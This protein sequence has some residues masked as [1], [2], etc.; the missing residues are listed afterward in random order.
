MTGTRTPDLP[1]GTF[2]DSVVG[3]YNDGTGDKTVKASIAILSSALSQISN[4]SFLTWA[5]L[6]AAPGTT[7]GQ[8]AEVIGD[9]NSHIDPATGASVVNHGV[10][11]WTGTVWTH[12]SDY[13][14]SALQSEITAE[15]TARTTADTTEATARANGDAGLQAQINGIVGPLMFDGAW[16]ASTNTPAL[17]S[18]VGTANHYRMVT[19]A[20]STL[21]DGNS[22]WAVGD[23]IIFSGT[24]HTWQRISGQIGQP[25]F[26]ATPYGIAAWG[27][28]LTAQV[29][30]DLLTQAIVRPVL[31]LGIAGDTSTQIRTRFSAKP[32]AYG[33]TTIIWAGRNNYS[34]PSTVLADIAAMVSA[35]GHNRYIILSV[36]NGN[37]P[38]EYIGQPD[39]NTIISINNSL[40]STYGAHYWDIRAEL[41]AAYNPSLP[42]DVIDHSND[43]PP[44]SL[45]NTNDFLHLNPAG[46]QI[47]ANRIA[48]LLPTVET[49]NLQLATTADV[50]KSLFRTQAININSLQVA[51]GASALAQ[52]TT[53]ANNVAVGA[54]AMHNSSSASGNVA[55]GKGAFYSAATGN[56]NV[57]IGN[58]AMGSADASNVTAVGYG[59]AYL[60]AASGNTAI[61]HHSLFFN[62]SGTGLVAVGEA[63]AINNTTGNNNTA[64]GFN[65][66]YVNS[67]GHGNCS[68]GYL[69]MYFNTASANCAFG[70]YA[71]EYNTTGSN[72]SIFGYSAAIANT[73]GYNNCAFGFAALSSNTVG[74]D[75]VAIGVNS[76]LRNVSGA[77]NVAVGSDALAANST[78]SSNT[79]IGSSALASAT[80]DSNTALGFYALGTVTTGSSNIGIGNGA[81]SGIT[82]GSNN[83]VIGPI[84]M[85]AALTGAII[86][87]DGA[88]NIRYDYGH[89]FPGAHYFNGG[90]IKPSI[91]AVADLPTASAN[92]AGACAVANDLSGA[93]YTYGAAAA[94][95]GTR[96][97][98]V[99]CDGTIW[100]EG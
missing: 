85:P 92:L 13:D 8:R 3:N 10:Y 44:T 11:S 88:G 66:S 56:Y 29:Y 42:Q 33:D 98:K 73:T 76:M 55:I 54:E 81:G 2:I 83:V 53:G 58:D 68:F 43:V 49:G 38:S 87:A 65:A 77:G 25:P 62:T 19:V 59:A 82:T 71:L 70:A 99:F 57:V 40:A 50:I 18:G 80:S 12:I 69:A 35:L 7:V 72:N 45:R 74:A 37:F 39:Y 100:R 61:G 64:V 94:G 84:G 75:N 96:L 67:V 9:A 52:N 24:S 27:D 89:A 30:P 90:P 22:S 20:G 86:I 46:D 14:V 6:Q 36:I 47:V 91:Y 32:E 60:N 93:A 21:I 78:N 16:N 15:T 51:V 79:A 48:A 63:S 4:T 41:V 34:D 28:S 97:G 31:N 23:L 1:A 5:A 95:G 26:Y 17:A